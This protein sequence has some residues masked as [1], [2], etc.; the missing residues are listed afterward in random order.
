MSTTVALLIT[1]LL[2]VL[3]LLSSTAKVA[4]AA[5]PL[6]ESNS[7]PPPSYEWLKPKEALGS[8]RGFGSKG[9]ES[10][11]PKGFHRSSAPSR[12]VNYHTLGSSSSLC[13]DSSK[14]MNKP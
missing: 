12:Y 13:D 8:R 5:R 4:V 9:L 11:L 2:Y 7:I 6:T 10:C 3:L 14:P 1:S